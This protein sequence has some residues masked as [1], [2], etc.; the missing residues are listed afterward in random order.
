[1]AF[2]LGSIVLI[3]VRVGLR[4]R[5]GERERGRRSRKKVEMAG[6][7]KIQVIY[8]DLIYASVPT[9]LNFSSFFF[10]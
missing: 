2:T 1:V 3:P 7:N 5:E 9:D 4:G 8:I 10:F 6:F